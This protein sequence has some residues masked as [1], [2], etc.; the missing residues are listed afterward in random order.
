MSSP[1]NR[2]T[3]TDGRSGRFY[4]IPSEDGTTTR[5]PSVTT[6]LGAIAK[7]ALVP[8]AAKEERLAVMEASADL[9]AE[10]ARQQFPRS[11]YLLALE[12]RVGKTKAHVKALAKASD[13]GT[14]AHTKIEWLMRRDLGQ[15]VGPEP[16]VPAAA[17]VAVRAFEDWRAAVRSNR[18]S[19]R[20]RT[21]SPGRWTCSPRSTARRCSR[22]SSARARSP[23]RS[24]SGCGRARRCAR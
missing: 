24:P 15:K 4:D 23:R 9:H 12:Q 2:I 18:P 16:L 5:M 3:R 1:S 8:W 6:I 21:S 11:M 14:A 22:C 10:C 7:P 20:A 19:T 13:I 17:A